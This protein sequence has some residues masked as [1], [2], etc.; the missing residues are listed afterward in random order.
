MLRGVLNDQIDLLVTHWLDRQW[1]CCILTELSE[2]WFS[3]VDVVVAPRC[4]SWNYIVSVPVQHKLL[5]KVSTLISKEVSVLPVLVITIGNLLVDVALR[6]YI[7]GFLATQRHYSFGLIAFF[8]FIVE[9]F[10]FPFVNEKVGVFCNCDLALMPSVVIR[11]F[12]SKAL[13]LDVLAV[14]LAHKDIVEFE[15]FLRLVKIKLLLL[16]NEAVIVAAVCG[17]AMNH[18]ADQLEVIIV[19]WVIHDDFAAFSSL[20]QVIL[21]ILAH[22]KFEREFEVVI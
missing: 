4:L 22:V 20:L 12:P 2:N 11:L 9:I 21:S 13:L 14:E 18:H 19:L 10:K 3:Q 6:V 16:L 15:P 1:S 8:F 7:K 5:N 17:T